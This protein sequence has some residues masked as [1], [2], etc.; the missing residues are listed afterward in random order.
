MLSVKVELLTKNVGCPHLTDHLISCKISNS[1]ISACGV[2]T[3][4][5]RNIIYVVWNQSIP[6]ITSVWTTITWL[7]P[8]YLERTGGI[9]AASALF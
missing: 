3:F 9:L 2:E 1:T 8:L 5:V 6:V 4:V 7:V